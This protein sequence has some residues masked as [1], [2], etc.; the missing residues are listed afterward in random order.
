ML[1]HAFSPLANNRW[2]SAALFLLL[3]ISL[4]VKPS[5]YLAPLMVLL[6]SACTWQ[7]WR[8]TSRTLPREFRYF[9][10]FLWA[11]CLLAACWWVDNLRSSTHWRD[12]QLDKP[13]KVLALLPCAAYLLRYPPRAIWLWLGAATG[14]IACGILALY[15][16]QVL[17]IPRAGGSYINP[18]EF[19]D[20]SIQLALIS[21]CGTQANHQHP[22]RLPLLIFLVTG[23]TLG[24]VGCVLSGTRGAWLAGLVA[25]GFLGWWYL[26]R[27]SKSRLLLVM[28]SLALTTTLIAQYVPVAERLHTMRQQIS[29]YWQQS[30]ATTSIGARLQ[31]WQFAADLAQQR[32]LIGWAQKGYDDER[33]QQLAQGRLDPFLASFNHPHNDYLDTA[34]KHGLPGLLALLACHLFALMYFW[35]V[36]LRTP[37]AWPLAQQAQHSALCAVGMMLPLLFASFGLTDT[38][39]TSSRTVVMYFFLAAFLMALVE[40]SY[41]SND[42]AHCGTQSIT[43]THNRPTPVASSH[44]AQPVQH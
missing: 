10:Y 43:H 6:A 9:R 33:H 35:Q 39:I 40:T 14:A 12:I 1:K 44:L 36:A 2:S 17:Q 24:V 22:R 21:L 41:Y 20:T 15:Q 18:I 27:H 28:L 5:N 29:S 11:A 32:P 30:D 16:V 23:F 34:A 31:M 7:L 25:L 42:K 19:G 4:L 3:S 8:S 13:L 37:K 38:H 26:G